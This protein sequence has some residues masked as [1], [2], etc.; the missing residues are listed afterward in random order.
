[1]QKRGN[2]DCSLKDIERCYGG[3]VRLSEELK[4]LERELQS[5]VIRIHPKLGEVRINSL[6][7]LISVHFT[8]REIVPICS[9]HSSIGFDTRL[10]LIRERSASALTSFALIC[11]GLLV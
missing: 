8:Q 10:F 1:M 3:G 11:L 6:L 7:A 9:E 4:A 2:S 5:N